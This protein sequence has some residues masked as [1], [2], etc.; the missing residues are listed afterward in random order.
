MW[1]DELFGWMLVTD[2]SWKHMVRAWNLGADGGGFGFYLLARTWLGVF[3]RNLF[4]YRMFS[5]AGVFAGFVAAWFCL[6]RFYQPALVAIALTLVW[7]DSRIALWQMVQTRFYGLLLAA[8]GWALYLSLRNATESSAGNVARRTTLLGVLLIN[9]VLV[10]SHPFGLA[11]SGLIL[12]AALIDD[13]WSG[14]R[15]PAYYGATIISWLVLIPSRTAL[16][17]SAKVGKPWF[18]TTRPKLAE[19]YAIYKPD[20]SVNLFHGALV[21]AGIVLVSLLWAR[22]RRA[23]LSSLTKHR[24]ILIPGVLLSATPVILFVLSLGG[25]SYFIDRYLC[26]F[27]IGIAVLGT[28]LLSQVFVDE[29]SLEAPLPFLFAAALGGTV[30]FQVVDKCMLPY[31]KSLQI[32]PK[33]FTAQLASLLPR[34]EPVVIQRADLFDLTNYYQHAPNLELLHPLDWQLAL[35]PT[36]GRWLVSATHEMEN[37]KL[38]GYYS[39]QIVYSDPFLKTHSHFAV[40]ADEDAPWFKARIAH[41]PEWLVQKLG[42]DAQ[43]GATIWQVDRKQDAEAER[44][45]PHQ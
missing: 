9:L 31:G 36:S 2:P 5:A 30:L 43:A 13:L 33:D 41:Q 38:A 17:N 26:P 27:L 32:P 20:Y 45:A 4:A 29:V 14:R 34:N 7:F 37:W 10:S 16:E 21:L 18:W 15:R 39:D 44:A 35:A 23:V 22:Q 12:L 11:Y 42:E 1:S 40:V 8:V 28:E 25:T 24:S 19:L 6:R 3:G